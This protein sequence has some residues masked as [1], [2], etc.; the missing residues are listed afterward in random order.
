MYV[1]YYLDRPQRVEEAYE[2]TIALMY[3]YNAVGN[4]E[5][6]KVGILG[7]AKREKWMQYFMRRP[8]VCSGDPSKKRS[9]SSPYGT[10]TSTAM[11]DHGL[12]L[13]ASYIEDYWEEMWFL[14]MLNQLLKYSDEKKGK[15]DIVAAL[16]MVEIADEELSDIIPIASTPIEQ[17]FQ[18][19]GYYKDEKGYTRFG[20]IP[21]EK[22]LQAKARWDLYEG[23]SVTSNPYY[24]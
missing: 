3:Y 5:A 10:T 18:D 22:K 19:I 6:S 8:R 4:L 23:R 11:I 15:F 21:K 12:Q 24:K 2:Q 13:V 9:S 20:V 1:A 17:Q 7:W 16:Q 14:D